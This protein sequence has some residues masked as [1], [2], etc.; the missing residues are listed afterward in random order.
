VVWNWWNNTG[1]NNTGGNNTTGYSYYQMGWQLS[2]NPSLQNGT[3][4]T[5]DFEATVM[6]CGSNNPWSHQCPNSN[7]SSF[8]YQFQYVK[9]PTSLVIYSATFST[10]SNFTSNDIIMLRYYSLNY[11]GNVSWEYTS[12]NG[13]FNQSSYTSSSLR[14]AYI[15][16]STFGVIEICGSIPG[17]TTCVNMTRN[18][19]PLYGEIDNP[20]NNF[21]QVLVAFTLII[22]QRITPMDYSKLTTR[23]SIICLLKIRTTIQGIVHMSICH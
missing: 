21:Q 10:S 7:E 1:G 18:I 17:D 5:L 19:R 14:T 9:P 22:L 12:S 4:I 23:L 16:A 3:M 8:S 6:N 13:T 20:S 11:S 2:F 15:Y